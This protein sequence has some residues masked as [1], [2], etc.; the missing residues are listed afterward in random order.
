MPRALLSENTRECGRRVGLAT[1]GGAFRGQ[2]PIPFIPRRSG[3]AVAQQ[4]ADDS[5]LLSLSGDAK[6][7]ATP[8]A[9][10]CERSSDA[11][12]VKGLDGGQRRR[13]R[14]P[15]AAAAAAAAGRGGRRRRSAISAA[16]FFEGEREHHLRVRA[17]LLQQVETRATMTRVLPQARARL[18]RHQPV[19]ALDHLALLVVEA[20]EARLSDGGGRRGGRRRP[21]RRGRRGR[22]QTAPARRLEQAAAPAAPRRCGGRR[23]GQVDRRGRRRGRVELG[24]RPASRVGGLAAPGREEKLSIDCSPFG[25]C[26]AFFFGAMAASCCSY[27]SPAQAELQRRHRWTAIEAASEPGRAS[28]PQDRS[29]GCVIGELAVARSVQP[30]A[31]AARLT[32]PW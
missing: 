1:G 32:P 14:R 25:A 18:H 30:R 16:A 24:C 15:A 22:L 2:L 27:G 28:S 26:F 5:Q 17:L 9:E 12:G 31:C 13:R 21:R 23:G 29:S 3:G 7:G 8:T 11:Q 19:A 20:G 10:P 6:A 4:L